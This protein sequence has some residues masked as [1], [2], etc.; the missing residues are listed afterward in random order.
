MPFLNW[1][2]SNAEVFTRLDLI[3]EVVVDRNEAGDIIRLTFTSIYDN[4]IGGTINEPSEA[5]RVFA[6]LQSS[7]NLLDAKEVI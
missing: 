6:L 5:Q 2:H 3:G 1:K 4:E 7:G